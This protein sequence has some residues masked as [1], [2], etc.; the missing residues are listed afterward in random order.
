[1]LILLVVT[2]VTKNVFRTS[3]IGASVLALGILLQNMYLPSVFSETNCR[4]LSFSS[5]AK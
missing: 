2:V 4:F 5:L 1:M 3:R